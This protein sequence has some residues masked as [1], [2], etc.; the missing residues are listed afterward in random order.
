MKKIFRKIG[1]VLLPV[2]RVK[3]GLGIGELKESYKSL[4][5]SAKDMFNYE[6]NK[7]SIKETFEEAVVRLN[8][9]PEMIEK[10]RKNLL[11][12]GILYSAI[13]VAIFIYSIYLL[14]SGV[15]LGTFISL[16]L[17]GIA[18]GLAFRDHFWYTQMTQ[19]RLGLS[20]KEWVHYTLR[21]SK[22]DQ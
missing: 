4:S 1:G 9:S 2:G 19:R 12:S 22:N 17:V 13:A 20:F 7:S 10:R 8:L 18:L 15:L 21:K 5:E 3:R 6:K 11:F 16:V 14:F